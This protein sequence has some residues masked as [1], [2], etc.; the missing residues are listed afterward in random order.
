MQINF[1]DIRPYNDSEIYPAMQRIAQSGSFPLLS[2]F[3]YPDKPIEQVRQQV[4]SYTTTR[5]FQHEVMAQMNRR[6]IEESIEEFS[7][8]GLDRLDPH[9][10]YLYLSNHRDI[11]LDSSLLQYYLVSNGFETTQ[12]TF[13]AN[14]MM[15]QLVTD[16]GKSNK[17]FRVERPGGSVK[18]F[19]QGSLHLS[20]YLRNVL[21][22]RGES[23]WMAQRNG[24]T[25]DGIDRTDQG[26]IKMLCLS[27][28]D[29][30]IRAINDLHIVPVAVSYE[31][32]S[33]DIL[34]T[35]ELY[36]SKSGPYTK[37]PGEDLT[38]VLTGILQPKGRVHFEL[39]RP[40]A[41]E[42]LNTLSNL[43][44]TAYHRAV[45]RIIDQRILSAYRLWPT[46]YVAH[47]LRYGSR[48]FQ[49]EYTP[50]L[51]QQFEQRLRCWSALTPATWIS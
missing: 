13:G 2:S 41:I 37:K 44:S 1:D 26:I 10:A 20:Q 12:I 49:N 48:Q 35:L 45:A 15:N 8:S 19:Y 14:L 11:V 25:K 4:A 6:V 29:D 16:I 9:G 7:V 5:D 34:K 38:S 42:E 47:D 23:V 51:R 32:E 27:L 21:V 40:L 43:T 24:R 17:M 39:C 28:R 18:E 22:E 3:L 31:W 46:N 30:K 50:Q 33:C 36:Q